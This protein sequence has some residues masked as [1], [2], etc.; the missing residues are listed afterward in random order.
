MAL[1]MELGIPPAYVLLRELTEEVR[2]L[3]LEPSSGQCETRPL[4]REPGLEGAGKT[5]G[6]PQRSA[7]SSFQCAAKGGNQPRTLSQHRAQKY[8][9]AQPIQSLACVQGDS[10]EAWP[11]L[12]F[13]PPKAELHKHLFQRPAAPRAP[14]QLLAVAFG[15][16]GTYLGMSEAGAPLATS[17]SNAECPLP[18]LSWR[19]QREHRNLGWGQQRQGLPPHPGRGPFPMGSAPGKHKPCFFSCHP[20]PRREFFPIQILLWII[21]SPPGSVLRDSHPKLPPPKHQ[22]LHQLPAGL[23]S[24]VLKKP[25]LS[26]SI[27]LSQNI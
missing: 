8:T 9:A 25:F 26:K 27:I 22:Q 19:L 5:S 2:D 4:F 11:Q 1:R 12:L 15:S 24:F 13:F 23:R 14:S 17:G 21:F 7:H 18:L 16:M 10:P 20:I 6:S 3:L